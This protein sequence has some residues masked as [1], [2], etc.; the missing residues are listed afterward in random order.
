M[1]IF[2]FFFIL[3]AFFAFT[4]KTDAQS[5]IRVIGGG[6]GL[7]TTTA[8]GL[9]ITTTS[10]VSLTRLYGED[11]KLLRA[12]ST[13]PLGWDFVTGGSGSVTSVAM[14]VPTGL[15]ISGSPV[16][17]SGTLAV[18]LQAGYNIPLTAST[19]NWN[20]FYDTPSN[21]ITDGT[22]LT[23][24]GNTLNC[25]TAS[26]SIQGCLTAADW[27]T[28]NGKVSNAYASST[29]PSF[30]YASSTFQPAGSYLTSAITSISALTGPAIHVATSSDTN[31]TISINTTTA[32]TLTFVPGFTGTLA[33]ARLNSNVVQAITNDTNVT[34][35]IS[36]QNLT[37]GWTGVLSV[38]RGGTATSTTATSNGQLL[39]WHNA[40]Y[41]PWTL[42]AG[43]NI[44]ITTTTP[45]IITI[46]STGGSGNTAWTIG[47]GLIYNATSTD[48]VGIG[49]I[50]PT[51]TLFV[52]GKAGVNPFNVASS[53]GT[54]L[55]SINQGG[56]TVV[57][58]TPS[59]SILGTSKFV[60]ASNNSSFSDFNFALGTTSV[61]GFPAL[62]LTKTNN[63]NQT[64]GT[65]SL[66][67]NLGGIEF[68]GAASASSIRIGAQ[69]LATVDTAPTDG[70]RLPTKLSF[71]TDRLS[72][73]LIE[74][75][76]IT[77]VGLVG[78]NST[79]PTAR[80]S[81]Q[82]TA[83]DTTDILRVAT[84]TGLSI[85][86][87]TP[88]SRVGIGSTSPVSVLSVQGTSG[89]TTDLLRVASS[90]GTSI[91]TV[92][93]NGR[94]GINSSTPSSP[95]TIDSGTAAG[96]AS[97]TMFWAQKFQI[98]TYNSAGSRICVFVVGTTLT[99]TSGACP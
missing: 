97:G 69:I 37:L 33:A 1:K 38:A 58:V 76:T 87:V 20:N 81:V 88:T 68:R 22:G 56:L 83:G 72:V 21:R 24:S 62:I 3:I 93:S 99:V 12:S 78:V 4:A 32:N 77:S 46:A 67:E 9:L 95:F 28:F 82:S 65:S 84:S 36:A 6:T 91:L 59:A 98:D 39:G 11:G 10:P 51:T 27:T 60:V 92:T 75:L 29:F 45:G 57:G 23:W 42:Q 89:A 50:T 52:Q 13:A 48:L 47:N 16:T 86:T 90:T 80:L 7:G 96:T 14:S 18:S 43:S 70:V 31:I 26:G 79:T 66:S 34:G 40:S 35:S 2:R 94:V 44:T 8:G 15:S 73:G 19:T 17:T 64:F 30:S 5:V 53:T 25:D 74:R 55:F 41:G 49:T 61:T 63:D 71:Y 54:S 85:L